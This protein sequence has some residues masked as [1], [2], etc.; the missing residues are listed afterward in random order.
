MDHTGADRAKE[1]T[2]PAAPQ[3]Q[4]WVTKQTGGEWRPGRKDPEEPSSWARAQAL[5][6]L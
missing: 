4:S 3:Q 6:P 1:E 2:S 5:Q